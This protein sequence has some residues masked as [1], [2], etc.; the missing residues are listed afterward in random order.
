MGDPRTVIVLRSGSDTE[1]TSGFA[2]REARLGHRG[3]GD[4]ARARR[5]PRVTRALRDHHVPFK[6]SGTDANVPLRGLIPGRSDGQA[7]A[8]HR[9]RP[10]VHAGHRRD[11]RR[12]SRRVS[13][14]TCLGST[15]AGGQ[16]PRKVVGIFDADGSVAESE[17]W[18]DA[19]VLQARISAATGPSRSTPGSSRRREPSRR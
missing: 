18:C 16:D 2:G 7:A 6:R 1:M 3:A 4:R 14:A 5:R 15:A 19:S 17:L 12:P 9:R 11:D 8:S 10:H 13:S